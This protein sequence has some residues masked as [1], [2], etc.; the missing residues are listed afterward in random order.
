MALTFF[1]KNI[2]TGIT[3]LFLYIGMITWFFKIPKKERDEFNGL[4]DGIIDCVIAAINLG[5]LAFLFIKK[6]NEIII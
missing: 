1:L 3:N 5:I 4:A 6:R 2:G